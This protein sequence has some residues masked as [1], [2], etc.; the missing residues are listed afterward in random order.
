MKWPAGYGTCV[1]ETT[2]GEDFDDFECHINSVTSYYLFFSSPGIKY[3]PLPDD[4]N[5]IHS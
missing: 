3:D 2:G 1:E 5:A 4:L